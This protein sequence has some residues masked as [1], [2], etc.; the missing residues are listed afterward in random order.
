MRDCASD[1]SPYVRKCAANAIP[2]IFVLD[3]DQAP[4]LWQV[5]HNGLAHKSNGE[6][7][8]CWCI[9]LILEMME[10]CT[11]RLSCPNL[12]VCFLVM[13][14]VVLVWYFRV[15]KYL[16]GNA[17]PFRVQ[18]LEKL[19]KDNNT[20][21]LGS[22]VAAFTEVRVPILSH[23]KLYFFNYVRLCNGLYLISTSIPLFA[24]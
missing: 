4:Q 19:L 13:P 7:R 1:S 23:D 16:S 12:I 9:A 15:G 20:M 22:A 5:S 18:V 10:I 24:S 21:V 2:K 8:A 11:H 3:P 17:I 6:G 14:S